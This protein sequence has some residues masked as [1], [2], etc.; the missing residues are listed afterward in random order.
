MEEVFSLFRNG[1]L[2][3]SVKWN[4]LD[5]IKKQHMNADN[6][7]K[8]FNEGNTRDRSILFRENE[9]LQDPDL[10][11]VV[12]MKTGDPYKQ[13][14]FIGFSCQRVGIWYAIDRYDKRIPIKAFKLFPMGVQTWGEWSKG[15]P[16]K[17]A[18][19]LREGFVEYFD[20]VVTPE[21]VQN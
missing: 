2:W 11:L 12:D 19:G 18:K 7:I 4:K 3:T 21:C 10:R 8:R 14:H 17:F 16:P 5:T 13:F 1:H 20:G 9:W 15:V 6:F